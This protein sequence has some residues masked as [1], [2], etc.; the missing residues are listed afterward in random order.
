MVDILNH[1][2]LPLSPTRWR[3]LP[4]PETRMRIR[5][6]KLLPRD[7]VGWISR[8]PLDSGRCPSL[9]LDIPFYRTQNLRDPE[10]CGPIRRNAPTV[11]AGSRRPLL[12]HSRLPC[13]SAT[14]TRVEP[15][16]FGGAPDCSQCGCAI[17][18]GL[19]WLGGVRASHLVK[20]GTLVKISVAV[21]SVIGSF[22]SG[23]REHPRW[24]RKQPAVHDLVQIESREALKESRRN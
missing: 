22:R 6:A 5:K 7:E 21:G 23:Y 9:F 8:N 3:C 20:I 11:Q 19:H 13:P 4:A 10:R 18:S 14:P 16:I 24:S 17:S 2:D 1:P 15:C 12:G